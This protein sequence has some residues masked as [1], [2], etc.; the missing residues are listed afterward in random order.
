MSYGSFAPCPHC[1]A[2]L[3]YLEGVAGSQMNPPCPR[4]HKIVTVTRAT[5][6]MADH[7]RPAS[8][9]KTLPRTE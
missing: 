3:S 4:C 7:S 8:A 1:G 2:P 6:L 9:G 5:F